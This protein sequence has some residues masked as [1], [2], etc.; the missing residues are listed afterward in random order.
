MADALQVPRTTFYGWVNGRR[1]IPI[2]DFVRLAN[3]LKVEN[4]S[5]LFYALNA[6]DLKSYFDDR[7]TEQG[8]VLITKKNIVERGH[9]IDL[10]SL[11]RHG[12]AGVM[13]EARV[14]L[15]LSLDQVVERI[16]ELPAK[17]KKGRRVRGDIL[18][19]Y[20]KNVMVPREGHNRVFLDY[21]IDVLDLDPSEAYLS[22]GRAWLPGL[23]TVYDR[24]EW[25]RGAERALALGALQ[26]YPYRVESPSYETLHHP[27]A[28]H[29][30]EAKGLGVLL[31]QA[32]LLT[33]LGL[34]EAERLTGISA[35]SLKNFEIHGIQPSRENLE[36]FAK[37]FGPAIVRLYPYFKEPLKTLIVAHNAHFFPEADPESFMTPQG[38]LYLSCESDATAA[39]RLMSGPAW[40][41]RKKFFVLR[42]L[43][44]WTREEAASRLGI[45]EK[46]VN[47]IENPSRDYFPSF[48]LV[49][50]L[51]EQEGHKDSLTEWRRSVH[52]TFYP[53]LPWDVLQKQGIYPPGPH[54]VVQLRG[55]LERSE[56][57]DDHL[58]W[59]LFK[60]RSSFENN[61]SRQEAADRAGI[62]KSALTDA[63][64]LRRP[65]SDGVLEA[66]ALSRGIDPASLK[67]LRDR[68]SAPSVILP[69]NPYP[70][71]RH[72]YRATVPASRRYGRA[73]TPGAEYLVLE[74]DLGYRHA[75]EDILATVG[76][77]AA[78]SL[79]SGERVVVTRIPVLPLRMQ[80]V[81]EAVAHKLRSIE[82]ESFDLF[83]LANKGLLRISRRDGRTQASIISAETASDSDLFVYEEVLYFL[84]EGAFKW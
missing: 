50:R 26:T 76:D 80:R 45:Y 2:D 60:L 40:N 41:F 43:N 10:E 11:R 57:R 49:R 67:S 64:L 74:A 42:I 66:V 32:R 44:G 6:R 79:E 71:A 12:F 23:I 36:I 28:T 34:D 30:Q 53:D 59:R 19:Q 13:Y 83:L 33:G 9:A 68:A 4:P 63:E 35:M 14:R 38:A 78:R 48:H 84:G 46:A 20:E 47:K 54:D 69:P 8:I 3:E 37:A 22:A 56:V 17:K 72:F 1:S 82:K 16:N 25:E 55:Y 77:L 73:L 62:S 27:R 75:L 15:G 61:E 31:R 39:L 24:S 29:K 52:Q 7:Q 81:Q 51:A 58:G 70:E 5:Q 65:T 18:S 21:L